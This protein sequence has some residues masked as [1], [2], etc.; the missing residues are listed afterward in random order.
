M[1]EARVLALRLVKEGIGT[2]N[3]VLAMPADLFLDALEYS[4]FSATF[5]E[6]HAEINKPK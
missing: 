3:E 1:D 6:T 4:N 5:Q 2:L